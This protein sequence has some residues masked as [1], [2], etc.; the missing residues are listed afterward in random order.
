MANNKKYR[1][2]NYGNCN[3]ADS[4]KVFEI[5]EGEDLKCPECGNEMLQ[6]VKKGLN[7]VLILTAVIAIAAIGGV[8]YY[9]TSDK[10][11]QK[12]DTQE[13][14]EVVDDNEEPDGETE[15]IT[16]DIDDPDVI[17]PDTVVVTKTDTVTVTKTDTVEKVVKETVVVNNSLNN[18]NLGWGLYTGQASKGKPDGIGDIK[19]TKTYTIDLKSGGK[20]ITVN[21]G[22]QIV[23]AKFEN[24][25][26]V[27]GTVKFT[28]GTTKYF[29]IGV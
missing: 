15:E 28:D 27:R 19:V 10:G 26:L 29:N 14:I 22:D 24:G 12:V 18:Y 17:G 5:P 2:L 3:N 11:G 8:V 6:E 7:W 20:T 25:K 13:P 23:N 4:K 9:L 1:C 16:E 21:S